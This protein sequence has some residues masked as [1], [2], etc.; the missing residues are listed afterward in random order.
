[1]IKE[2]DMKEVRC[3][4]WPAGYK[5]GTAVFHQV[6]CVHR[7]PAHVVAVP[8]RFV[9]AGEVPIMYDDESGCYITVPA[10][11]LSRR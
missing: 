1:M 2:F 7:R 4:E 5:D 6:D 10:D 3:R 8:K 9:S 11:D